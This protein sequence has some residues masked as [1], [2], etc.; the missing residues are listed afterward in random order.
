M[1]DGARNAVEVTWPGGMLP[2]RPTLRQRLEERQKASEE[3]LA[4]V[5]NALKFLDENP[6]FELFHN[7]IGKAGF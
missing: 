5:T 1:Y 4:D 3:Y 6:S 7:L 2:T